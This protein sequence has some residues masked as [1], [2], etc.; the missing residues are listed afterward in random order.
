MDINPRNE[1]DEKIIKKLNQ[2]K[3]KINNKNKPKEK[4][5][6]HNFRFEFN[7]VKVHRTISMTNKQIKKNIPNYRKNQ[8]F[9][10]SISFNNNQRFRHFKVHDYSYSGLKNKSLINSFNKSLYSSL[11]GTS[12]KENLYNTH[13]NN[14][15]NN[16]NEDLYIRNSRGT[17]SIYSMHKSYLNNSSIYQTSSN[18]INSQIKNKNHRNLYKVVT[19]KLKKKSKPPSISKNKNSKIKE[20]LIKFDLKKEIENEEKNNNNILYHQYRDIIEIFLP[21]NFNA[22]SVVNNKIYSLSEKNKNKAILNYNK[23]NNL[24]TS[25]I[26]Y[27]G[28]LHKVT[29]K[30]TKGFKL[31]KRYFQIT[32]NCF[33]Y[34]NSLENVQKEDK[35]LVQFDIRHIKD[36]Q[37]IENDFLIEYKIDKKDIEMVFCIYLNQNNDF[38]VFAVNNENLGKSVFSVLNLLKNYY[39]DKK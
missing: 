38:F 19:K 11:M 32:K 13:S 15:S 25:I 4:N 26:L 24:K 31:S 37:I 16:L 27:D 22:E 6:K 9:F 30:K 14:L 12:I 17:P 1:N 10:N 36:L 5:K 18:G 33:R 29:D 28:I 34:Y 23:L 7:P 20:N 39:E 35:P 2:L 3:E 8:G 21:N